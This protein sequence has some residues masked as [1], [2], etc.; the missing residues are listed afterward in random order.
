MFHF[1]TD[2]ATSLEITKHA[3]SIARRAKPSLEIAGA[4]VLVSK[5][6]SPLPCAVPPPALPT[7][8]IFMPMLPTTAIAPAHSPVQITPLASSDVEAGSSFADEFTELLYDTSI[9]GAT[10]KAF[11][12][13]CD[14]KG[15][16]IGV[17][18]LDNASHLWGWGVT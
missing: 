18:V 10:N 16:T 2:A 3:V 12:N 13:S 15:P 7:I 8:S 5:T 6:L 1:I 9:H 17:F 11:H 14:N 4:E